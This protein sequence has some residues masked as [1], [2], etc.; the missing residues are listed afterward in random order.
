MYDY[1]LKQQR[2]GYLLQQ[3]RFLPPDKILEGQE[4]PVS[5][6]ILAVE[7]G[8]PRG[9]RFVSAAGMI[10]QVVSAS[11]YQVPGELP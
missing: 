10:F 3:L 5:G 7:E 11:S 2:V 9:Q 8:T 1:G 6:L 4:V